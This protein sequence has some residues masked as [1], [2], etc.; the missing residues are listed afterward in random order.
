MGSRL[1]AHELVGAVDTVREGVALLFDE[2][3]LATG[4][5]ELVGQTDG[6]REGNAHSEKPE[7]LPGLPAPPPRTRQQKSGLQMQSR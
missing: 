3:A 5:P 1:T 6:C 4:T 2:D 7:G